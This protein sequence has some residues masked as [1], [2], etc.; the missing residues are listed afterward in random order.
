MPHKDA[1]YAGFTLAGEIRESSITP[2][3]SKDF[4]DGTI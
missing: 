4:E 1:D 2:Y 3:I